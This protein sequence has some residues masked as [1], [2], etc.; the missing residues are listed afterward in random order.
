M[1]IATGVLTI[2]VKCRLINDHQRE[3]IVAL[4][5]DEDISIFDALYKLIPDLNSKRVINALSAFYGYSILDVTT[6]DFDNLIK[7]ILPINFILDNQILPLIKSDNKLQLA[8][9]DP[10]NKECLE[11]VAFKTGLIVEPV[12]V[13]EHQLLALFAQNSRYF[14]TINLDKSELENVEIGAVDEYGSANDV[15]NSDDND[16]PV[17]K[18]VHKMIFD[19]VQMDASDIHFEPYEHIYRVRYRVDGQLIEVATPPVALKDKIAARI[20]IVAKLDIAE[21]RIPQDGRLRLFLSKTK[22]IDFRVSSLPTAFGEKIVLRAL[23]KNSAIL[24]IDLLGFTDAQKKIVLD[25]I[26][27]PYGMILVTGPT[28]SGKTVTLYS[29][30]GL[31]NNGS[32]NISA[33]E[34]PIEIPLVGINQVEVNDK[35]GLNFSVALRAFLRQDPDILMVGEIRDKD[36]A[37]IAVKA[38]QTGHLLLSTLHTNDAS[39]V[40]LRLVNIGVPSYNVGDAM[41]CIIAQ[42]LIRKLCVRCKNPEHLSNN[43][44]IGAGF[45]Q[46]DLDG[47]WTPFAAVGCEYCHNTGYKGRT[48]IFEIMSISDNIKHLILNGASALEISN[49]ARIEGMMT[50]RES[51]LLK[52]RAGISSLKEVEAN[53][54]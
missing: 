13:E 31:L 20:K 36:T 14:K 10:T 42:R 50:L 3:D 6:L 49:Q 2:L 26:N 41:L 16:Q 39:S 47:Q 51:G 46:K 19:A 15:V 34:D 48:G 25:N 1:L 7:D 40:I 22:I 4:A 37:E 24:G 11:L 5:L 21:K 9:V 29:C 8:V 45:S 12:L 28:G 38:A 32:R 18:F 27:R 23:D 17:V 54:R 35:A 53:T 52:V 44:L 33:V 30:L 43:V